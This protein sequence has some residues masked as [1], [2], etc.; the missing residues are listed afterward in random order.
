[1]FLTL[2]ILN[3]LKLKCKIDSKNKGSPFEFNLFISIVQFL[4]RPSKTVG[5][6]PSSFK[7]ISYLKV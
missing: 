6:S 5:Y 2:K 1:M 3:S 4:K 7:R